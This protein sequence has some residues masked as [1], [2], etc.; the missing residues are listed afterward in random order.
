MA[1]L[2]R[3]ASLVLIVAALM[4][5][6]ADAVTS[7]EKGGEVTVRS[8]DTVWSLLDPATLG[9]FKSWMQNHAAFAAQA[10]Y[11]ALALPGWSTTG[12]LGVILA[13]T[14]GRKHGPE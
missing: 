6:G 7:L 3:L 11:S 14:F 5:L 13:F 8:L 10:I 2:M 9:G 1:V 12:V 4:L